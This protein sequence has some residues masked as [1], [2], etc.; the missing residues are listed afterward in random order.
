M[1]NPG[2]S[3]EPTEEGGSAGC[4]HGGASLGHAT[5]P[6]PTKRQMSQ[7]CFGYGFLPGYPCDFILTPNLSSAGEGE[8]PRRWKNS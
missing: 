7:A 6:P 4:R 1:P 8:C 3:D 5:L 2:A